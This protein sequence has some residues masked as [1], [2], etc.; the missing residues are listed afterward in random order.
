MRTSEFIFADQKTKERFF[1][2][3]EELNIIN[4][5]E[6]VFSWK[7]DEKLKVIIYGYCGIPYGRFVGED[8][9]FEEFEFPKFLSQ[10]MKEGTKTR[11]TEIG[12]EKMKYLVA[13]CY[14]I[15]KDKKPIITDASVD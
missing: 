3:V 10:F 4:F 14:D 11:I 8:Q 6:L 15:E 13:M 2:E 7:D 12:Y 9:D 5:D 1:K